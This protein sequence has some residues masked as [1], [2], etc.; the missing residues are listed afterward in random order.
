[1]TPAER[2]IAHLRLAAQAAAQ[3]HAFRLV[4]AEAR[5]RH[6][7]R[8]RDAYRAAHAA[9]AG[10]D[11]RSERA[12]ALAYWAAHRALAWQAL[13]AGEHEGARAHRR[14]ARRAW[15]AAHAIR[16]A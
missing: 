8:Q 3:H 6:W 12:I 5:I 14:H 9:L 10:H 1:M 16:I 11:P 4:R 2:T 7:L 13:A 15:T